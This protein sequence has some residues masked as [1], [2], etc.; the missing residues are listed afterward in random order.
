MTS[1][2]T[3]IKHKVV[4]LIVHLFNLLPVQNNKI[5][6]FSYYGSQFGCNPKYITDYIINNEPDGKFDIVWA[7]N[8]LESRKHL[9]SFRK[10]KV[11]SLKY[12]YELCT[13]KVVITNFRTTE[14]FVKRKNQY[15]I[16]TWHSSLR[17]KQIEKDAESSLPAHYLQMAKKDSQ[18]CDLLLS[19]CKYSSTIF[20]RAFWYQGEIFE[21]GIPR[22]DVLFQNDENKREE[23]LKKLNIKKNTKIVL[24]APTFRKDHNDHVY[25][26]DYS[27]VVDSLSRKF[28]GKWKVLVKLHP[29]LLAQSKH[30]LNGQEVM[31][32][33]KYD[34]IQELLLVADVLIS[35]YSSL[36]FDYAITNRPCFLFIPDV[37][38]YIKKERN[39]YFEIDKLPFISG[40]SNTELIDQ[41]D[42][43]NSEDYLL[44]LRSF[45]KGIES[46]ENGVAAEKL[47][48]KIDTICFG[49]KRRGLDEAV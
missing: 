27:K 42:N 34:D 36:I 37:V 20:K 33:T 45:L 14:Y 47:L 21:H 4:L 26:V 19:G 49:E 3:K 46:Y 18:K 1:F 29:H 11:M 48:E 6:L 40:K 8:D 17:L 39:L 23:V 44:N 22:N 32:V 2:Y 10:V 16:Q 35:D 28:G 24:Y 43:F 5:F 31:D 30:L 38:E 9:E 13:S 25:N 41:I 7:F 15:Y 12:F